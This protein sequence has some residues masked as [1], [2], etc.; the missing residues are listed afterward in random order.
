[1]AKFYYC[2]HA[3]LR[4]ETDEGK[5]LYIDPFA[6]EGYDKVAD[7]IFV[8]HEHYDHNKIELVKTKPETIVIRS[9]EW[10]DKDGKHK[11][12]SDDHVK[13]MAVPAG[14]KNHDSKECVG[15]VLT[16]DGVKIYCAGDTSYLPSMDGMASLNLDYALLPCDG[17]FNMGVEEATK[18]AK[19]LKA[20]HTIPI[21]TCPGSLFSMDVARKLDDPSRLIVQPG[22]E[23]V[24]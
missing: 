13:V 24:L 11:T 23:I 15:L 22:E 12:F 7:Y 10:I 5:F 20:K 6:G 1:M 14:N 16:L 9:T 4:F 21:H 18:V 8:T 3:S 2:G 17:I 19:V